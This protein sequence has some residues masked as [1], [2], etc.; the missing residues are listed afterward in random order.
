M[1]STAYRTVQAIETDT[2]S[3]LQSTANGADYIVITH[4]DFAAAGGSRCATYRA[5][6]GLRAVLVD[7]QDVYDEFGYGLTGAAAI[8]DFLAYAYSHW[9]APAPSY[10]VLVG[11]GHYDPKNYAGTAG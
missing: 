6:Q 3:N 8:H 5:S 11:D 4:K 1:A 10:V 9:Q 2:A 7:V